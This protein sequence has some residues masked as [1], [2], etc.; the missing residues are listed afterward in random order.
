MSHATY[1]FLMDLQDLDAEA[2]TPGEH[3]QDLL[4]EAVY[5][6]ELDFKKQ[7][8][9]NNYH[10]PIQLVFRDRPRIIAEGLEDER[11]AHEILEEQTKCAEVF[12]AAIAKSWLYNANDFCFDVK[13]L[14][15]DTLP[16]TDHKRAREAFQERLNQQLLRWHQDPATL[17]GHC[18]GDGSFA[19]YMTNRLKR[20]VSFAK[21]S[22]LGGFTKSKRATPYGWRA[23]DLRYDAKAKPNAILYLDIHT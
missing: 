5:R 18:H 21:M 23:F 17:P 12:E 9:D 4:Q 7:L 6:Y 1:L 16:I 11:S 13:D 8:D 10:H 20:G 14:Q 3:D 19:R 2:L 22:R 15:P